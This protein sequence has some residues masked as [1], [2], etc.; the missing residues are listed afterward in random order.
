MRVEIYYEHEETGRV[1]YLVE[2][3]EGLWFWVDG[4]ALVEMRDVPWSVWS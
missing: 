4:V 3:R 1:G 2:N